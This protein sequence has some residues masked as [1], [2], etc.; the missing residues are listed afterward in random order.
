M[1]TYDIIYTESEVMIVIE[2]VEKIVSLISAIL[3]LTTVII[4]YKLTKRKKGDK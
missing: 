4:A 2:S 1:Y 3:N